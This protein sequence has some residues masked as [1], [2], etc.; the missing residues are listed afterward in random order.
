MNVLQIVVVNEDYEE[1]EQGG[2]CRRRCSRARCSMRG[3]L[4]GRLYSVQ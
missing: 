1:I 2:G 3:K 4:F